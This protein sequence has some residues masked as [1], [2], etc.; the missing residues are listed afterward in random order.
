MSDQ[1]SEDRGQ[2]DNLI[3]LSNFAFRLTEDSKKFDLEIM[4]GGTSF[5]C[6]HLTKGHMIELMGIMLAQGFDE[7]NQYG[8]LEP[9]YFDLL[10]FNKD[11]KEGKLSFTFNTTNYEAT[12][13]F[14]DTVE[15]RKFVTEI[16]RI[17]GNIPHEK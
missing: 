6:Y 1:P 13:P 10:E 8:E 4:A 17:V 16:Q 14:S 5:H 2:Y 7:A 9:E 15:L 3:E 11:E 12:L